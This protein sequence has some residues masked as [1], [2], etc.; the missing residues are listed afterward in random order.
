MRDI[1]VVGAPSMVMQAVMP[2]LISFMNKMLFSYASAVFVMGVYYRISTFAILPCIGLN[3]GAMPIMGYSF[4]AKNR[5]RLMATFKLG[6][7]AAFCIMTI[8]VAVFMIFPH[9]IMTLFSAS[10]GT[11]DLGVHALRVICVA[12]LPASFIFISVGLFQALA[13]GVFALII[14]IVRQIGFI[15]PLAWILLTY[16]GLNA[17]WYSYPLAEIAALTL[18]VLFFR[19]IYVNQIIGLPDGTPVSG[20]LSGE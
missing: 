11:M 2:I 13:H 20:R 10:E 18:T 5:L 19:R 1:L 17:V 9:N 3:Q 6:F 14:S 4:G 7:K 15:L 16:F 8:G 12:W